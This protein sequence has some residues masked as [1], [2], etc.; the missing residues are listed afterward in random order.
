MYDECTVRTQGGHP[1]NNTPLMMLSKAQPHLVDQATYVM[2][3]EYLLYN[4]HGGLSLV[5]N[6]GMNAVMLAAGGGNAAFIAWAYE[7][8]E[9][10]AEEGFD[11]EATN[12][13]GRNM[14]CLCRQQH[15]NRQVL[16][17]LKSLAD[18][19]YITIIE[20]PPVTGEPGRQGGQSNV[21][22]RHR[23][24]EVQVAG[25]DSQW[26]QYEDSEDRQWYISE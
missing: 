17:K 26:V 11:W 9:L 14:L 7:R 8:R 3:I 21:N 20:H 19:E 2:M 4:G 1:P 15:C 6:H 12:D 18:M 10:I 5:D 16:N 13:A 24:Q 25:D 22:R 23:P